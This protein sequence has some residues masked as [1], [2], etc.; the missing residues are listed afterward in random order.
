M[1]LLGE[2]REKGDIQEGRIAREKGRGRS[3]ARCV[4]GGGDQ[5]TLTGLECSGGGFSL[6][7]DRYVS[8]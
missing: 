4:S 8:A 1:I 5:P 2:R 7:L 6:S 3:D